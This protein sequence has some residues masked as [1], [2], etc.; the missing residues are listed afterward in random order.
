MCLCTVGQSRG[1]KK[2]A[3]YELIVPWRS[4][5]N[6][7][8]PEHQPLPHAGSRSCSTDSRSAIRI[9]TNS[10][11]TQRCAAKAPVTILRAAPATAKVAG[12][13]FW[14]HSRGKSIHF[15]HRTCDLFTGRK[16]QLA[17]LTRPHDCRHALKPVPVVKALA[18]SRG[19]RQSKGSMGLSAE[20]W[21]SVLYNSPAY[22]PHCR[23]H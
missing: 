4:R 6:S 18:T 7:N 1:S 13:S 9:K 19:I 3:W 17:I 16:S 20:Y 14:Q 23:Q 15:A 5:E 2:R 11:H 10:A 21:H 8:P 12:V 22:E